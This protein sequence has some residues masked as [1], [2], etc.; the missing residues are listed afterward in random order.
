[1]NDFLSPEYKTFLSP[2]PSSMHIPVEKLT[3]QP[4]HAMHIKALS[5]DG[6]VEI[7]DNLE[8][9]LGTDEAWYDE[10][11]WLCHGDLGMQECHDV[12]RFF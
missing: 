4:A 5:M 7:V 6:N 12:T 3:Q 8:H 2:I 1:M 11:I 10:Y 9:Q